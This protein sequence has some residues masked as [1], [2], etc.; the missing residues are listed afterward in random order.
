MPLKKT[1]RKRN[2]TFDAQQSFIMSVINQQITLEQAHAILKKKKRLKQMGDVGIG[3][4][5]I[6]LA[7]QNEDFEG[8]LKHMRHIRVHATNGKNQEIAHTL[9]LVFNKLSHYLHQRYNRAD[10]D[11]MVADTLLT[12]YEIYPEWFTRAQEQR[13]LSYKQKAQERFSTK[14]DMEHNH[15]EVQCSFIRDMM[16]SN[17][18]RDDFFIQINTNNLLQ[19]VSSLLLDYYDLLNG[20]TIHNMPQVNDMYQRITNYLDTNINYYISTGQ[21]DVATHHLFELKLCMYQEIC[22]KINSL[23]SFGK[24]Q[25]IELNLKVLNF[26]LSHLIGNDK[27]ISSDDFE[28]LLKYYLDALFYSKT[29]IN[30][31]ILKILH[32]WIR[33]YLEIA[34]NPKDIIEKYANIVTNNRKVEY[35]NDRAGL[36]SDARALVADYR[37]ANYFTEQVE[38]NKNIFYAPRIAG[39]NL[40]EPFSF[41]SKSMAVMLGLKEEVT[42][43]K[44][45]QKL[46]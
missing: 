46:G 42:P 43:T 8:A 29:L 32:Q 3:F 18:N 17:I 7:L 4:L 13:I 5:N 12:I 25:L 33:A 44:H 24:K 14:T 15:L 41:F 34:D 10:L 19:P 23:D 1:S 9:Y 22:F 35:V 38:K 27:A 37:Y 2:T 39:L 45:S 6:M 16:K 36:L 31:G 28:K 21:N 20:I 26:S 30:D 40:M 11:Y